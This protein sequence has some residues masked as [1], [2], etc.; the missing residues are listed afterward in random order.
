MSKY[1]KL[2]SCVYSNMRLRLSGF[3]RQFYV[4]KSKRNLVRKETRSLN[5]LIKFLR[6]W[7]VLI[8]QTIDFGT[9]PTS[10]LRAIL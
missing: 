5:A 8:G 2:Q 4:T 7:L 9:D 3:N 6:E 10:S 1:L